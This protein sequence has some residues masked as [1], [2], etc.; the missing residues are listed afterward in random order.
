MARTNN[1]IPIFVLLLTFSFA[2]ALHAGELGNQLNFLSRKFVFY[3]DS[4]N[5][6]E[7]ANLF[8]YPQSYTEKELNREVNSI[9]N[10]LKLYTT[11]IGTPRI[12]DSFKYNG[13]IVAVGVTG[14]DLDYWQQKTKQSPQFILPVKF[15]NLGRGFL[16]IEFCLIKENWEIK[17]VDFG[18]PAT[19]TNEQSIQRLRAEDRKSGADPNET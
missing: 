8:H 1:H 9:T 15:G 10:S 14:A 13:K 4:G 2:Q 7:A 12:I 18:L 3:L 6:D 16:R 19:I 5:F 17:S 11:V